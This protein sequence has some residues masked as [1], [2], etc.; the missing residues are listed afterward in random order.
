MRKISLSLCLVLTACVASEPVRAPRRVNAPVPLVETIENQAREAAS[1]S[2]P[3]KEHRAL[4]ALV[5]I[6]ATRVVGVGPDGE[7]L[8]PRPGRAVIESAL[9]GRYLKWDALL[10]LGSETHSTTGFLGFDINQA[11]YQL[12]MI[13][14]LATGMGVA[15]GR[16]DLHGTGVRFTIEVPDPESGAVRRAVS[17]LRIVDADRFVLEQIGVDAAQKERVVRRTHYERLKK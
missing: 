8:D 17:I 9:G 11:E 7:D 4:E 2:R 10:D 12:L 1:A 16:G 6:Y 13:S 3:R 14:D 5:G 15:R